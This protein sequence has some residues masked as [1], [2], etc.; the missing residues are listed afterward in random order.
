MTEAESNTT[1]DA[2]PTTMEKMIMP[3]VNHLNDPT[4]VG[5]RAGER[6]EGK[7]S[8]GTKEG[9]GNCRRGGRG[10]RGGRWRRGEKGSKDR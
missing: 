1:D 4:Q 9:T 8:G 2:L 3:K 6:A 10:R 7:N 5:G